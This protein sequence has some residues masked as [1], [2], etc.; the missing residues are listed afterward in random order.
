M[1]AELNN[2]T[3]DK[4]GCTDILFCLLFIVFIGGCV[5]VASFGF[6]R[7]NPTLVMYPYDEDGRQCGTGSNTKYPYLYFYDVVDDIK[8][9]NTTGLAQGICVSDCPKNNTGKLSC[10]PTAHNPDCSVTNSSFY[11]SMPCN[12][13]LTLVLDRFCIP[14]FDPTVIENSLTYS[15]SNNSTEAQTKQTNAND[16]ISLK[17]FNKDKLIAWISDLNTCAPIIAASIG[18]ALVFVIVYMIFI[19]C[20][21]SVLAYSAIFLILCVLAG[22]GYVFQSRIQYYE[23][24]NEDSY[25]LTMKVLCGLFYSLAGIWLLYVLFMCNSIRLSIALIQASARYIALHPFL[26][27]NPVFMLL[28]SV[29]WYIYWVALSVYLY[30][31][32]TIQKSN[33]F[34]ANIEW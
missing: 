13:L 16:L 5:V 6:S 17:I 9:F 12:K 27:L 11:I 34:I 10:L 14:N 2:G 20:C 3:I 31:T 7:G 8:D 1:P 33:S 28:L 4:R 19:R 24:L 15:N 21:S 29:A 22:L 18:L 23:N 26:F 25:V 30:T 32:G